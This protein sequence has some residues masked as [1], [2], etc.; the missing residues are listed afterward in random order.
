MNDDLTSL[1]DGTEQVVLR[2]PGTDLETVVPQ[3]LIRMFRS[4]RHFRVQETVVPV[5]SAHWYL[6]RAVSS[7]EPYEGDEI[8]D[9]KGNC[10][11]IVEVNRSELNDTWQCV[12][13][14]YATRFGLDEFVDHLRGAYTKSSGGSLQRG[15][16]VLKTGI[17]AK[18]SPP[19]QTFSDGRKESIHALTRE[20]IEAELQDVLRRA[21]G[22]LYTIEKIQAPLFRNGWTEIL[23]ARIKH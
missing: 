14:M 6:S 20:S 3:A 2:R 23:L 5:K 15:F 7:V 16:R 9:G 18:F 12:A 17:A 10:W 13:R 1:A 8:V 19:I 11:T 22:T 4:R 21:D